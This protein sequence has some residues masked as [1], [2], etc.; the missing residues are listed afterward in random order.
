MGGYATVDMQRQYLG[1]L[2]V[3][4]KMTAELCNIFSWSNTKS[5]QTPD[6]AYKLRPWFSVGARWHWTGSQCKYPGSD[7]ELENCNSVIWET[8]VDIYRYI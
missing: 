5:T 3:R 7:I 2:Q 4:L 6:L 1:L 8:A